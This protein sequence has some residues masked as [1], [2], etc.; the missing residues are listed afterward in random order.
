MVTRTIIR[1]TITAARAIT[2]SVLNTARGRGGGG[3]GRS[4]SHGQLI[5]KLYKYALCDIM[6]V[7]H[8]AVLYEIRNTYFHYCCVPVERFY[9][10]E[11]DAQLY[12][13][14]L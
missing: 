12:S 5:A 3:G 14:R 11:Q 8:V 4:C 6:G 7:I 9:T 1:I 13:R 2:V 10:L